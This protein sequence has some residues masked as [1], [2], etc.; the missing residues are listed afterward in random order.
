MADCLSR[1]IDDQIQLTA[2]TTRL[3][4]RKSSL[5]AYKE[6]SN[7]LRDIEDEL[8]VRHRDKPDEKELG[9]FYRNIN[10]LMEQLKDKDIKQMARDTTR[11][12]VKNGVVHRRK[13]DSEKCRIVV[14]EHLVSEIISRVHD[15]KLSAHGGIEKTCYHLRSVWFPGM[16][17]RIRDHC[18][19]CYVCLSTKGMDN[20]HNV[21]YTRQPAALI[22][23]VYINVVGRLPNDTS[24][25][26][27]NNR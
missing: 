23:R 16:R 6:R 22:D 17:R 7:D 9:S 11:Y 8:P 26:D 25:Y 27:K 1:D 5:K 3:Q 18:H 21:L 14:P 10:W 24:S 15:S 13:S 19:S 4:A 2:M 12:N 20:R